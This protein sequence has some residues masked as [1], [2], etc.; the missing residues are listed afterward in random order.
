MQLQNKNIV[1]IGGT[2]GMGLS[3]AKSFIMEGA[4]V[5]VVGRNEQS[6]K[7]A[8]DI[9]GESAIAF[10]GDATQPGTAVRPFNSVPDGLADLTD[11]TMWQVAADVIWGMVLYMNSAWKAG[12]GHCA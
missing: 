4:R 10:S 8:G 3:A 1:I 9:L 11:Y 12:T 2:T 7:E 5:V 6:V